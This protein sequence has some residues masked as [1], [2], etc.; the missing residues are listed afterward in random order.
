MI[1]NGFGE[2]PLPAAVAATLREVPH[3]QL[4]PARAIQ[5]LAAYRLAAEHAAW[6]EELCF[7][8]SHSEPLADGWLAALH[9]GLHGPGVGIVGA[10]GSHESTYSAAPRPLKPLRKRQY[11]PFPNP[12]LRT[13]G[14]ML[15]RRDMLGLD[16]PT[17]R[18]KSAAHQ[19][20]SGNGGITR[21]LAGRGLAA[22]VIDRDGRSLA[23]EEWPGSRTYRSGEQERLLIADNRTRQYAGAPP[24]ERERLARMAFGDVADAVP[25]R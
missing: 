3:E 16:W 6:A 19:L 13:N 5:D 18:S 1:A 11:P 17:G 7:V 8:N 15:R 21:Q 10:T 12:H 24:H 23:P 9:E 22:R 20:E 25:A 2:G 4:R 14:F